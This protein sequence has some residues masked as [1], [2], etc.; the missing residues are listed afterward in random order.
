MM[1]AV[2]LE[3][4]DGVDHVLDHARPGDLPVLGDMADQDH[5]GAGKLGEADQGLSGA[6]H[7]GHRTRRGIR[8]FPS[9]WSGSN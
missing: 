3:G 6:A 7:L 4:G 9:T 2:A 5:A 1:A 8:P